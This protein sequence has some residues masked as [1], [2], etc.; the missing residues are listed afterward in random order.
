[1]LHPLI[2]RHM[3]YVLIKAYD[4]RCLTD[5]G[6]SSVWTEAASTLFGKALRASFSDSSKLEFYVFYKETNGESLLVSFV[7]CIWGF[8]KMAWP[9]EFPWNMWGIIY[10]TRLPIYQY[11]SGTSIDS[12]QSFLYSL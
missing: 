2:N 1:M 3:N 10:L 7:H 11:Q 12:T 8:I 4:L 6:N 5:R 9:H